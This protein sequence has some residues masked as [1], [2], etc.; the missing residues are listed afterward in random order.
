MRITDLIEELEKIKEHY[1][2]LNVEA[3][4][5]CG[6]AETLFKEEIVIYHNA[7]KGAHTLLFDL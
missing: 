7:T 2:D 4:N 1:G 5:E 3:K 6:T